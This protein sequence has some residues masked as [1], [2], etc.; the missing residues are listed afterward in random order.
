MKSKSDLNYFP[1]KMII[2]DHADAD[3]DVW[4]C[5]FNTLNNNKKYNIKMFKALILAVLLVGNN[6]L[7]YD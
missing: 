3:I 6:L 5:C 7:Y 4:I 2:A 1:Q